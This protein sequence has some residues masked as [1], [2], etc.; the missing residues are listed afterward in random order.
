MTLVNV[1][2]TFSILYDR[3]LELTS[4]TRLM[5]TLPLQ[6]EHRHYVLLLQQA[7]ILA[8]W[9]QEALPRTSRKFS[10]SSRPNRP[11]IFQ[12]RME[13]GSTLRLIR[14]DL[15]IC[16]ATGRRPQARAPLPATKAILKLSK[17]GILQFGRPVL[18]IFQLHWQLFAMRFGTA[19]YDQLKHKGW[20]VSFLEHISRPNVHT[21]RKLH[22]DVD[23]V[24]FCSRDLR[25]AL[26]HLKSIVDL[27][28]D[29]LSEIIY[30]TNSSRARNKISRKLPD[31]AFMSEEELLCEL[32]EHENREF[33]CA[34]LLMPLQTEDVECLEECQPFGEEES[35]T[36]SSTRE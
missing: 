29:L 14:Q 12:N 32:D 31:W 19:L 4:M 26:Y 30:G 23:Q 13:F 28:E 27:S 7:H 18:T 36:Y 21:L 3:W 35:D 20:P 25:G 6:I 24:N 11:K 8:Y 5:R 16:D 10:K 34:S 2:T 1:N 33:S 17:N 22:E 9:N 15:R